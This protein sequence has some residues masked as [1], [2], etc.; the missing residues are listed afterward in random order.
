MHRAK[1]LFLRTIDEFD[2]SFQSS[3]PQSLLG[4]YLGPKFLSEGRSVIFF[5]PA[6]SSKKHLAIAI[7]Y[8]AIQNGGE[9]F[10][11]TAVRLIEHLSTAGTS[12]KLHDTLLY[13]T[14]P[15]VLVVDEV[16]YLT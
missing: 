1:F 3:I 12:G 16:G 10:F 15:R 14:R 4:S 9:D 11:T 5:G 2:F 13:Y 6:G 7:A 8:R